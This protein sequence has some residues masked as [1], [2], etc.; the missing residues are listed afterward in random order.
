MEQL[1]RETDLESRFL[2]L[3]V[4]DAAQTPRVMPLV[5][6]L[7]AYLDHRRDVLL[8]RS[9]HRLA[10]IDARL[11]I[12]DGYL[13]AY[14]N[15]DE[16]IRIIRTE[17]EPK[18]II[19][20][21]WKL[22]E[23]QAEAIL[24]L[25]LRALRRLEEMEIKDEHRALSG[26]K[27]ELGAL[28]RS[29][30][31]Q[32]EKVG[33]EVTALRKRYGP[34]TELGRRRTALSDAPPV[35]EIAVEAMIEREPATIICSDKGWIRAMRGHVDESPD[36]KFKDGDRGRF[37]IRCETTDKLMVFGTNGKFYTL[38]VDKLPGGRG[39]GE[40]IR[41]MIDLGND[42]DIVEILVHRPGAKRWS[43]P[44]MPGF[45]VNADEVVAQTRSGKQVLTLP[46]G[47]EAQVCVP[48]EGDMIACVGANRKLLVF[49]LEQVPEMARGRGVMLQRYKDG[50]LSDVRVFRK[51][52]GLS[53]RLG[54]KTRTET[55]LRNWTGERAQAGRLPPNGFPKNNRFS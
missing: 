34:K 17:D 29:D 43:P 27:R 6:A 52:E 47:V 26:E 49:P 25:R 33:E 21:R 51:A 38:S 45:I 36:I 23:S 40:P 31:K 20:R 13:I 24:N 35:I 55:D 18:P 3:N 39:H 9:R 10:E 15:V 30:E 32:W 42:Q 16:I 5:E 22:S 12:L 4:L 46:A 54:D 7:R 48:A 11:E 37:H 41:L 8:R 44:P 1:F 28:L 53:W 19:M 50:G 14:L 2:N